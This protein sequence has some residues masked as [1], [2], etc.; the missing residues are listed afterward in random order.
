[1]R[2]ISIS[3]WRA[4]GKRRFG[5]KARFW[6]FKC[7]S[8]GE[9]Q[10]GQDFLSAGLTPDE[11][12]KVMGY[13]CIGRFVPGRGCDWT[14]GGLLHIHQLEIEMED[15]KRVPCFEFVD[16]NPILAGPGRAA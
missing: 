10:T 9:V 3:D 15:G 11:V 5:E 16:E 1:M 8:C 13:S 2:T 12:L 14:L 7:V 4:E 6:K